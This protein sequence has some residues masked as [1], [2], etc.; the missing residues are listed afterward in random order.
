MELALNLSVHE[1]D[2]DTFTFSNETNDARE[3]CHIDTISDTVYECI[4]DMNE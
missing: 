3:C 1:V 4:S 2:Y